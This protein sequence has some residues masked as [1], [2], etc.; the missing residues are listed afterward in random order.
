MI[1]P[2]YF[3]QVYDPISDSDIRL[4]GSDHYSILTHGGD[5]GDIVGCSILVGEYIKVTAI[6]TIL[7]YMYTMLF[8][9]G[10]VYSMC[11][12]TQLGQTLDHG[13]AP[14]YII[15]NTDSLFFPGEDFSMM[16]ATVGVTVTITVDHRGPDRIRMV[17]GDHSERHAG[18]TLVPECRKV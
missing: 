12:E 15:F 9:G 4:F 10:D 1:I 11:G 6:R 5:L 2:D 18:F 16:G 8:I 17:H 13:I 14:G 7:E 3:S